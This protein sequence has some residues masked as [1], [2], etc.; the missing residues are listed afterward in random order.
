[1]CKWFLA[2]FSHYKCLLSS[3]K[4]WV[5]GNITIEIFLCKKNKKI[6]QIVFKKICSIIKPPIEVNTFEP[7]DLSIVVWNIIPNIPKDKTEFILAVCNFLNKELFYKAPEERKGPFLWG[8]F[9]DNIM[10]KFIPNPIE[11][12][13]KKI[14]DIYIGKTVIS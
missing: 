7:R 8:F 12:W 3:L 1:M 9:E 14:V 10:H 5:K 13:E 11:P 4:K 2:Y 6:E